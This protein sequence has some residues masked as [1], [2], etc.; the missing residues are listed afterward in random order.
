[1]DLIWSWTSSTF[2]KL[3]TLTTALGYSSVFVPMFW[4]TF[5]FFCMMS[6]IVSREQYML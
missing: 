4:K 3:S 6:F 1:M 5:L 2:S